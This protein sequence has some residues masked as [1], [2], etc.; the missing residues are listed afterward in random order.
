MSRTQDLLDAVTA[1]V[2]GLPGI[3]DA[4]LGVPKAF[5]AQVS[6][7][8]TLA[9]PMTS[10]EAVDTELQD[11]LVGF[12]YSIEDQEAIAEHVLAGYRDAF[13]DSYIAHRKLQDGPFN[14]ATNGGW[15]VQAS[16]DGSRNSSPQY[17]DWSKVEVRHFVWIITF[18]Y[19]HS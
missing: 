19:E 12:G 6:T 14:P 15:T 18:R 16:P 5:G 10:F 9:A 1:W 11:V 8:I 3:Q 4:Q 13:V 7:Y 17:L 2:G